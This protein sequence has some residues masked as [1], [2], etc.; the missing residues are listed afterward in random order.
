MALTTVE[1]NLVWQEVKIQLAAQQASG[2]F[3]IPQVCVNIFAALK[4]HLSQTKG[5]PKLFL[6]PFDATDIDNASGFVAM[7]F[8]ATLYGVFGRKIVTNSTDTYLF[9]I[10][11]ASDDTGVDVSAT[12][13]ARVILPF[14]T[15]QDEAVA[16]FPQ[17][18]P[19]AA[20]L[21]IKAY[22]QAATSNTGPNGFVDASGSDTPNGFV[23][24]GDP[25]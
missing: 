14:L 24:L 11:D 9:L 15:A 16:I 8:P 1:S 10:D 5:N 13:D 4:A 7:G 18:L 17:G 21:V 6:Q 12:S 20:G 23:I 25:L 3:G 2:R 22:T 19:L